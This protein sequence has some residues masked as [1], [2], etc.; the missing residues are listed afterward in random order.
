MTAAEPP[1]D[2]PARILVVDDDEGVRD[3]VC[4]VLTELGYAADPASDGT[5]ALDR[6]RPGRY[7]LVVTDLTMPK[8]NGLQLARRLRALEPAIPILMF[9][10]AAAPGQL[11][12]FGITLTRKPDVEGLT[13]LIVRTLQRRD[14]DDLQVQKP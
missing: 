5:D 12:A 9:S 14:I 3:T 10:A 11:A 2:A 6:F 13:R 1:D 7:R 8:M 4:D